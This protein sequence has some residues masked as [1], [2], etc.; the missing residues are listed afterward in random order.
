MSAFA[1]WSI[2]RK[3]MAA[4][5][6]VVVVI[7]ASSAIVYG[8]L[9]VIESGRDSRIHTTEVLETL[10]KAMDAMVDQETGVR[11]YLITGDEK[12][13]EPYH[14]GG[15]AYT[16]AIRKIRELTS[17]NPAQQG[18]LDELN[19][20]ATKWRSEIAERQIA[21]MAKPETR[22]C[23]RLGGLDGRQDHNG[24]HPRQSGR[25]RPG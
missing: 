15:N 9:L 21:L 11:G 6:A 24:P 2:S 22:G 12:F 3:F 13:L 1:N 5:A 20:L 4:F 16:A 17:D 23:A 8:R 18:R 7:F 19:E 10:Q 14:S 25:N